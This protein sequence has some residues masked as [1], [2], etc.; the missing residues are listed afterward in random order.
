MRCARPLLAL[1]LLA[2]GANAGAATSAQTADPIA[3]APA[4]PGAPA[5][6]A[7]DRVYTADQVSNTVSVIDP[8]TN[9]LL[10]VVPLGATRVG[11]VF[12]PVY[13]DEVNVHGLGFAPDGSLL[14][15]IGVTTNAVTLIDPATN[16]VVGRT[17][18]G[19]APHEGFISPDGREL[20]VAVRGENYVSVL[21]VDRMRQAG[22]DEAPATVGSGAVGLG[23]PAAATGVEIARIA[24]GRGP[25]M[26]VFS[27]DGT[28]AYVNHSEAAE[29]L[30]I[31]VASRRVSDRLGDLVSP[32]SPNLAVSPDGA[33]IWVTHKDVGKVTVIDAEA[34]RVLA[35]VETGPVTNHVT[36]VT[37]P[38]AG[39][40]YVTVGGADQTLV[41][42]RN[43]AAPERVATIPHTGA[44]P[45][46]LWP[47]AD[48]SR[49]YVALENADAVDVIDTARRQVVATIPVGQQPQALVYV[50]GAVPAGGGAVNL[51]RQGLD[52]RVETIEAPVEGVPGLA[53]R[54]IVR[55]LPAIDMVEVAGR[56]LPP[57]RSYAVVLEGAGG[58]TTAVRLTTTPAG[59]A[60]ALAFTG[61][62]GQYDRVRLVPLEPPAQSAA[63]AVGA[64]PAPATPTP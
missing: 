33:E 44:T 10:G 6:S 40:A 9:T 17:Y 13:Y 32:F 62:F 54:V 18:V 59:A 48:N 61:F 49:V 43:G 55:Q 15:V 1:C 21:D 23:D 60:N 12:S 27:P 39:Y 4:L 41:F 53:A 16:R 31:D 38:D 25:S 14:G 11:S 52:L 19:R 45:H 58:S 50:A 64:T 5:I 42:R 20:W 51:S 37:T 47:S 22:A 30:K 35:V 26:V 3:Q 46:G 7:T 56:G 36:F 24:T 8:S 29:I 2:V 28:T 63:D 34:F 57:G